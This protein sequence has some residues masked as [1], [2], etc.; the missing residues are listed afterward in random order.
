[1]LEL[2]SNASRRVWE[3]VCAESPD[4]PKIE[5]AQKSHSHESAGPLTRGLWEE[6][7]GEGGKQSD[8]VGQSVV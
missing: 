8:F 7:G 3:K 4:L 6:K 1:M 5:E 2:C